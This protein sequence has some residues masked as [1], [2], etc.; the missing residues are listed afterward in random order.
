[1]FDQVEMNH[2]ECLPKNEVEYSTVISPTAHS[3]G[4]ERRTII[5]TQPRIYALKI[6]LDLTH[7]N[8]LLQ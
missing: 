5:T 4:I 1:M 3:I 6:A 8:I 2:A 7:L